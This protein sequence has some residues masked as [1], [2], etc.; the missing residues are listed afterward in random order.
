MLTLALIVIALTG[1][2]GSSSPQSTAP[3]DTKVD[4]GPN[5]TNRD[6][7]PNNTVDGPKTLQGTL[8]AR[9]GCVELEGKAA[10]EPSTQYQLEFEV[11]KVTRDGSTIVLTGTDGKRNVGPKDTIY[12]AGLP[13]SGSG[14][15]GKIFNVEKVVA[16]T[17]G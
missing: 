3:A 9:S 11:E 2:G 6:P 17:P 10:N 7:G 8:T 5:P 16:V 1:C 4:P 12:V 14:P 13:G 15:C